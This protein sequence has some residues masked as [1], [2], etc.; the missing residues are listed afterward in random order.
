MYPG[1]Y[2]KSQPDKPAVIQPSTGTTLTYRQLDERSN[3]LAHLLFDAGLRRGDHVALFLEN[4][5]NFFEVIW[6][7]L[8]SGMYITPINC[9][10]SASAAA[11]IVDN[12]DASALIASRAL[13]QSEE[14]GRLCSRCAVK[15]SIG[16]LVDGFSDY[17][18]ALAEKPTT[19]LAE[20]FLG[21]MMLYSSGTTGKPKGV[22]RPLPDAPA[23]KGSPNLQFLANLFNFNKDTVYL[24]PAP[25]YHG[26]P[27]G[28]INAVIQSGGTGIMMDKFDAETAL[29]LIE[30]YKVTHSQWVPAM[31]IKM[32]KLPED[33]RNQYDVSSLKCAFHAAA[34][35]PV[36]VKRRMIQWW[37]PII[38]EYYTSTEN[39][40]MAYIG[41]DEWL[42]HPGSVGRARGKPFH[43]C[44]ESGTE[45]PPGKS[46]LIYGEA[47]PGLTF[48]YHKDLEKTQSATHPTN[49]DLIT[50]GD[51]GYLDE[52]GY[53]FLTDR[54]A[55]MIISGGVNIYPQQ[56]EDV[57]ALHPKLTDVA[58]IGVPNEDLGE[59]P[60]A[61]VQLAPGIEPSEILAEE[62][63]AFVR[64]KLGKQLVP[65]S[66]DF[67]DVLPRTPT[68]KLNKK[69]IQAKYWPAPKR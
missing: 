7:C 62:I 30:H 48:V 4:H 63:Q 50:V 65:R 19:M 1:V 21:S 51:I 46:G 24:S 41:S 59:E 5:L 35:C 53:L 20:E 6:A 40:G 32:L 43:I 10:L 58:V 9:H 39:A 23:E 38:E 15:L 37:G 67:V 69:E 17:D 61:I 28:Y 36:D 47:P 64:E 22:L 49:P 42:K 52:E 12:C 57:L 27:I 45:L 29:Q 8:R 34:P 66:I 56:I 44:D 3:Q 25:L 68:G 31:F 55:F 14:L 18:S 60:K 2:A 16:G 54:Q 33:V 13:E 26:A 11:Y